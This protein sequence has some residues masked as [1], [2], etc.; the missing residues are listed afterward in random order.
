M[1]QLEGGDLLKK[2]SYDKSEYKKSVR[3]SPT[4][5]DNRQSQNVQDVRRSHKVYWEDDGKL[6]IETDF[7]WKILSWGESP[8]KYLPGRRP[9]YITYCNSDDATE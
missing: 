8:E 6:E 9:I 5:M 7:R 2:W 4:K 3:Q 1:A